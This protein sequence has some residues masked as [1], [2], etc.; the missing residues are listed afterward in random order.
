VRSPAAIAVLTTEAEVEALMQEDAGAVVIEVGTRRTSAEREAGR[1][2]RSVAKAHDG[3]EV[4]FATLRA[5]LHP[6]LA[7]TFAVRSAP[8]ILFVLD[9]EILDAIVGRI[10]PTTLAKRVAWLARRA[11]GMSFFARLLR[12]RA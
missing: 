5:D 7:D 2:V 12:R 1:V 10:E 4:T 3:P 9:G 11:E 6:D 8:T